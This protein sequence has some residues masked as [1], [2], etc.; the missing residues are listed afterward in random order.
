[1][2]TLIGLCVRVKLLR[3]LP[4]RFKVDI[5]V[6]WGWLRCLGVWVGGG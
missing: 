3:A 6:G 4:A 5:E 2:A 1:M